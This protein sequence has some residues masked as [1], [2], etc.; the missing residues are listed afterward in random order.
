MA[1]STHFGAVEMTGIPRRECILDDADATAA[2]ANRNMRGTLVQC[3]VYA[4]I[5]RARDTIK[6]MKSLQL[7]GL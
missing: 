1:K 2:Q 4:R 7:L 5:S 3:T 6:G